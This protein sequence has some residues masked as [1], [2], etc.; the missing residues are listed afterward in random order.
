M[1]FKCPECGATAVTYDNANESSCEECG[2]TVP[3]ANLVIE[4]ESNT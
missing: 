4:D 1:A 2:T 3:N